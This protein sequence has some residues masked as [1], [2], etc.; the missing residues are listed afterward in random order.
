MPDFRKDLSL[1]TIIAI[2]SLA[3]AL[4][5]G[6]TALN[7]TLTGVE[8][9]VSDH[10]RRLGAIETDGKDERANSTRMLQDIAEIKTDLKYLREA[11]E[12]DTKR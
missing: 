8:A 2:A 1:S 4:V 9:K 7:S 6:W 3:L 10:D 12:R 5:G 11:I